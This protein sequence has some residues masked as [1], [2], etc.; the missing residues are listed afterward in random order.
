ML[1]LPQLLEVSAQ[2][3]VRGLLSV[4]PL[5]GGLLSCGLGGEA[6]GRSGTAVGLRFVFAGARVPV[7]CRGAEL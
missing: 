4:I 1:S 6:A 2:L 3:L 7:E 5:R